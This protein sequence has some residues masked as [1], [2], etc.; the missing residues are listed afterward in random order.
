V[1]REHVPARDLVR[2]FGAALLGIVFNQ[3]CFIFGVRLTAPGDASII[4]TSMPLWAMLLAAVVL[5]EPITGKKVLGIACGAAGALLLILGGRSAATAT[6]AGNNPLLGDLLVLTAQLSY[7]L[8][9]VL[10]K[11]FV[12]RYSL[13]TLMKWMFTFSAVCVL[14]FSWQEL[15]RAQWAALDVR[16][17]LSIAFIVV[18]ATF[19]GYM[20]IIVGQ[21]ALRPTVAGMY[22]YIQP[23]VACLIAIA[24]GMDTFTWVKAGAVALIFAGVY[25][26]TASKSRREARV[27][28]RNLSKQ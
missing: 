21:K 9:I 17:W 20:L 18:G 26:V 3:G 25:L 14:P 12:K 23:I 11:N 10:Y 24:W 8:Y 6:A 4:T 2:L 15:S 19:V 1:P 27:E 5:K 13:V 22:N 7:A 28:A 16:Q